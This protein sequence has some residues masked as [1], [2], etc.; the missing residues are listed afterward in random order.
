MS[1]R[2][3]PAG[4]QDDLLFRITLLRLLHRNFSD[5]F[6]IPSTT[7]NT[8]QSGSG[9]SIL[10]RK[11]ES[12]QRQCGRSRAI[13]KYKSDNELPSTSPYR[14][15]DFVQELHLRP[16]LYSKRGWF[17]PNCGVFSVDRRNLIFFVISSYHVYFSGQRGERYSLFWRPQS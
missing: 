5:S 9:R 2:R 13:S 12:Q 15:A 10:L 8:Y 1:T 6:A 16:L 7:T 11:S 17:Q 4:S 3:F 14:V